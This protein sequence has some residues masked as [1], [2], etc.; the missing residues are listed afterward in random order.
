MKKFHLHSEYMYHMS[1]NPALPNVS[2]CTDDNRGEESPHYNEKYTIPFNIIIYYANTMIS[3]LED[4]EMFGDGLHVISHEEAGYNCYEIKF[5]G[6]V[7]RIGR[8]DPYEDAPFGDSGLHEIYYPDSVESIGTYA[9]TGCEIR[10][11]DISE[12]IHSIGGDAFSECPNLSWIYISENVSSMSRGIF[13]NCTNL[14]G[15]EILNYIISPYEFSSCSNLERIHIGRGIEII[16]E[17]AFLGCTNLTSITYDGT[18]EEWCNVSREMSSSRLWHQG[19][20]TDIVHCI[21]GDIWID[22][23]STGPQ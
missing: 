23:T 7:T 2:I 19:V 3:K 12:N 6:P 10:G 17:S 20:P 9:F 13:S 11:I 18:M 21:D 4:G 15:A 5:D 22:A 16:G 8:D 14:Q 1:N